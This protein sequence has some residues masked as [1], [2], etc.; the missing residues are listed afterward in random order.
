MSEKRE[1]ARL[2]ILWYIT[3]F[4]LTSMSADNDRKFGSIHGFVHEFGGNH[5]QPGDLV[6]LQSSPVSP[7]YL[8]WLIEQEVT[9]GG[10][11]KYLCES[12]ETGELAW[13]T[14]VGL[15]YLERSV[16][17][18]NPQWRWT[19]RQFAFRDRWHKVCYKDRDAYITLPTGPIFGDGYQVTLGTRTRF[20][21]DDHAPVKIFDDWRK[22]TKAIM[23]E[24]YDDCVAERDKAKEAR[25]EE[26]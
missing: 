12:I 9:N 2:N 14:N 16:V 4:C 13:W 20:G 15:C 17:A 11:H 21:W 22:V 5:A 1:R 7:W 18:E 10:Y 25:G 3:Q 8:S 23:A 19:D 6:A 24:F 26:G